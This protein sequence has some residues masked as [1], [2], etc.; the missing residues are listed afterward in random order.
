M[1]QSS[2]RELFDYWNARRGER[3]APERG[4][5]EP[6]AIRHVLADTFILAFDPRAGHPFRVAGTRACALLGRELKNAAFLDLW[7]GKSRD[8]M[9][10]LINVVSHEVIGV[11][12]GASGANSEGDT[13]DLELLVLPLHHLGRTDARVLGALA[14]TEATWWLGTRPLGGLTLGTL[15]YVGPTVTPNFTPRLVPNASNIRLRHGLV[16]YDGGQA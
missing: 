5:I 9:G 13:L 8:L 4:D 12:A 11:V 6:S 10:D 15:R 3:A 14:P 1:K 7:T 2:I 16:V